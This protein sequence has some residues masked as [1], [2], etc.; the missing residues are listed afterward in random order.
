MINIGR[1]QIVQRFMVS[2]MVV[3]VFDSLDGLLQFPGIEVGIELEQLR[4]VPDDELQQEADMLRNFRSR[5]ERLD[6]DE[7]ARH[8]LV[9]LIVERV[10]VRDE[11]V[12]GMT[13][14]SNYHLVLN[15]KKMGQPKIRLAHLLSGAGATG[16]GHSRV[17]LWW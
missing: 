14:R 6:E 11:K 4:P 7:E 17:Y 5:W 12:V 9:K 13:L 10:H 8:E 2:L 15:Q 16:M 3:I 1:C